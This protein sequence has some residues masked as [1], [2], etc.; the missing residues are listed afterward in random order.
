MLISKTIC[1]HKYQYVALKHHPK[2]VTYLS[3]IYS[4]YRGL[5]FKQYYQKSFC[6]YVGLEEDH[7]WSKIKSLLDRK[8]RTTGNK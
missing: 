1:T 3:I 8:K 2:V 5:N 6:P 7:L 4:K